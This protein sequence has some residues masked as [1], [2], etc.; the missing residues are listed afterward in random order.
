MRGEC[1]SGMV[2][3]NAPLNTSDGLVQKINAALRCAAVRVLDWRTLAIWLV[4][5][6]L[7]TYTG[8]FGTYQTGQAGN[9][10]VLW[11]VLLGASISCA[12][13]IF[14][15]CRALL[16]GFSP[17]VINLVFFVLAAGVIGGVIDQ[18]LT[19]VFMRSALERPSH[20]A[21]STYASVIML[22]IVIVRRMFPNLADEVE[23]GDKTV[24]E[25]VQ[26]PVTSRLAK[27]LSISAGVRI[28]RVFADG[29]FVE[30]QTC[31]ESH[32]L[33]MRFSDAVSELDDTAGL[34]VHRS[35]WV[36][37]GA[38][39]GWVPSARKP[40]VVLENEMRVPV[41]KTYLPGVKAAGLTVLPD[42]DETTD[43]VV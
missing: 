4:C 18:L 21:L 33:R 6:V 30:V 25:S 35:H 37:S 12:F 9:L 16:A 39:R 13:V 8:P 23:Q 5:A 38:I 11:V 19:H 7:A 1:G 34:T 28:I 36:H 40:Y 32:R 29:H 15:L 14:E 10:F 31:T 2:Y 27:R 3:V 43:K 17:L 42:L 20:L 22:I 26:M 24:S 41:S